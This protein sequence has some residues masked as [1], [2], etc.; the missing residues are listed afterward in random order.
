MY[1]K[2]RRK[3]Y[4]FNFYH[5]GYFLSAKVG[6]YLIL[7]FSLVKSSLMTLKLLSP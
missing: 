5:S 1:V 3:K 4:R 2:R 7:N 6:S